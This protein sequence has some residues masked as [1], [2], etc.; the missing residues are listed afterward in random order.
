MNRS[1]AIHTSLPRIDGQKVVGELLNQRFNFIGY[2]H[3]EALL[4]NRPIRT[5]CPRKSAQT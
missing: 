5:A 1:A 4:P 2:Q 3:T